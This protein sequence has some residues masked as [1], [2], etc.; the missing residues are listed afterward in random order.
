[1]TGSTI[2]GLIVGVVLV[3]HCFDIDHLSEGRGKASVYE[4]NHQTEINEW[5]RSCEA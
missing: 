5:Q 3:V 1:M 4:R 2:I